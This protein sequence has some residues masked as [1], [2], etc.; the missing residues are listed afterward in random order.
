MVS[1]P[2]PTPS[3]VPTLVCEGDLLEAP[4]Q[5]VSIRGGSA[6]W[7]VCLHGASAMAGLGPDH[8]DD[9]D[10]DDDEEE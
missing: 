6:V 1:R 9:D 2:P 4:M 3:T 5:N 7:L 10:D 8:D